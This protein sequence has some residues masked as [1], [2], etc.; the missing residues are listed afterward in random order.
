MDLKLENKVALVTGA[1]RGIG[2]AIAL[3]LAEEGCDIGICDIGSMENTLDQLHGHGVESHAVKTDVMKSEDLQRFIDECASELGGIDLLVANA[4][5]AFGKGLL[6]STPEDWASTFNLNLF[7]AVNS[8]RAVIPHMRER[9]EGS[10]LITAS[11]SGWKPAPRAQYGAAKA[12]E[13]Y[14]ARAL[15][16]ELAP[17]RI[18]VNTISPGSTIFP[19]GGWDNFRRDQPDRYH[20]FLES[21]FPWD[22]F[23]TPDDIAD[24]AVFILS[25]RARWINGAN[26]CVDGG[27]GRPSVDK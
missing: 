10:I 18:R 5:G 3:K 14:V 19:E 11:I 22:R 13:I 6:E 8:I 24:V 26:I 2:Q 23:A 1:G 12:A 4:G 17:Y 20:E 16:Q 9:G 27:Q 25:E 21:E 15:V 7:H